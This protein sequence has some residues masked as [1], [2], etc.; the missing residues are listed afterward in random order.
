MVLNIFKRKD[1][2]SE[3]AFAAKETSDIEVH[4]ARNL[5]D[6]DAC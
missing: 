1:V 4:V 3:N 5:C 2:D 6:H